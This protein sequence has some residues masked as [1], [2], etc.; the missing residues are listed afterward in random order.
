MKQYALVQHMALGRSVVVHVV[1][2][3]KPAST[4]DDRG[5]ERAHRRGRTQREI[6]RG[7]DVDAGD[8]QTALDALNT[9]ADDG[10]RVVAASSSATPHVYVYADGSAVDD[11]QM[12]ITWTL[13]RDD[14]YPPLAPGE[15]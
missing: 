6:L 14:P 5:W 7:D 1:R 3:G 11:A 4:H 15:W 2:P 9:L 10:W 8:F 13:E 12:I